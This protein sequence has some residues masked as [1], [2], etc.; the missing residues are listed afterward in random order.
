MPRKQFLAWHDFASDER[1]CLEPEKKA[2]KGAIFT[3]GF[4]DAGLGTVGSLLLNLILL[5]L[6]LLLLL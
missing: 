3:C 4:Q 6:L 1:R 5:L 2:D